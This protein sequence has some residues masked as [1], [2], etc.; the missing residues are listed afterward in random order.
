VPVKKSSSAYVILEGACAGGRTC[1]LSRI[2]AG[3]VVC[4]KGHSSPPEVTD[5]LRELGL[6]E[7][8]TIKLVSC[9]SNF[10][11]QVCEARLG[12]SESV[13]DSILV[14][15]VQDHEAVEASKGG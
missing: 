6:G 7:E 3:T 15:T 1:P 14:E 10:I 8:R 13:A 11:C 5:R 2:Q 4:I 12:L 9:G